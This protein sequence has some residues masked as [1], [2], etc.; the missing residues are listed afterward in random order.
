MLGHY[1]YVNGIEHDGIVYYQSVKVQTV[2]C[3]VLVDLLQVFAFFPPLCDKLKL[4]RCPQAR[5]KIRLK[6]LLTAGIFVRSGRQ[7][8]LK[9]NSKLCLKLGLNFHY[10]PLMATFDYLLLIVDEMFFSSFSEVRATFR[11]H[12]KVRTSFLI[13]SLE[14]HLYEFICNEPEP[15]FRLR[16]MTDDNSKFFADKCSFGFFK[17]TKA[18]ADKLLKKQTGRGI[19]ETKKGMFP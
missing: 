3:S 19:E 16:V 15:P 18:L 9:N 2:Q 17:I 10:M 1:K 14:G 7:I 12:I 5:S 8:P 11:E 6:Y 13:Y 4:R